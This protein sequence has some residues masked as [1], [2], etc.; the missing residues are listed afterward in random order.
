MDDIVQAVHD[1]LKAKTDRIKQLER[2]ATEMSQR[3]IKGLADA[4]ER[5]ENLEQKIKDAGEKR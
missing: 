2:E 1:V 5:I 4:Y 3:Y